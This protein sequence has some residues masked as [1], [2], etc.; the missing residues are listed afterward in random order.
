MAREIGAKKSKFF[1]RFG[2][3]GA[4]FTIISCLSLIALLVVDMIGLNVLVD[5]NG[6]RMY[7]VQFQSEE[8]ILLDMKYKRGER[9]DKPGD[10][11]HSEDEYHAYTFRGWDLSGDGVPDIIPAHAYYSFLAIAVYQ[12][13]QI[14]P[15]PSSEE[16]SQPIEEPT[17][18]EIDG[19]SSGEYHG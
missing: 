4:V 6:P 1:R 19:A 15:Y 10:P 7:W 17:S 9:V 3:F 13:I 8:R 16:E 11:K 12:T 18:S 2:L 5:E 14:K